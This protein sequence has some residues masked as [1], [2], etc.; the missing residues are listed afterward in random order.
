MTK[1]GIIVEGEGEVTSAPVLLRRLAEQRGHQLEVHRPFRVPRG[2]LVKAD[3]LHRA[4]E[5]V[6][7]QVGEGSPI[8]V[9]L[10]ADDDCIAT[11]SKDMTATARAARS[12]RRISVVLAKREF[13]AWFL[14]AIESLRGKRSVRA[15]AIWDGDPEAVRDAKG[16]LRQ[17]T[18]PMR[19]SPTV[20]QAA[21][22]SMMDLDMARARSKSFDKLCR[23]VDKLLSSA[24]PA[25][26]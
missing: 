21:L 26:Q 14:A 4:V 10:D 5:A 9:L 13:E 6:A 7:R 17:L 25:A 1:L 12:D 19:Y 3:E 24:D 22:T 11:L 16:V 2:K 23:E 20:D 18:E 8:L 15:D